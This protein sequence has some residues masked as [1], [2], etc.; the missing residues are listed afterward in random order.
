MSGRAAGWAHPIEK[1][2][3]AFADA[4]IHCLCPALRCGFGGGEVAA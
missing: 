2:A 4:S 1:S 3:T